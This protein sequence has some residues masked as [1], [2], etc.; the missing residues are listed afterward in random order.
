[1]I[2]FSNQ[3]F[4]KRRDLFW[5]EAF[6][7][8]ALH[9]ARYIVDLWDYV[10]HLYM[11]F[12]SKEQYHFELSRFYMLVA[13]ATPVDDFGHPLYPGYR[14]FPQAKRAMSS[15]CSRLAHSEH[16]LEG[17]AHALGES[18]TSFCESWS[19][20]VKLLNSVKLGTERPWID[21]LRFPDPMDAEPPD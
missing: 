6:L 12:T 7:G 18:S 16:Y 19:E 10:P 15:L 11:F 2:L 14:L 3:P 9:G 13:L 8:N 17:V 1:L 20:R 5:P 21:T 4:I